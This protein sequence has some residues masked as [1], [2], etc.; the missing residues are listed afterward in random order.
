MTSRLYCNIR[1][2]RQRAVLHSSTCQK[3]HGPKPSSQASQKADSKTLCHLLQLD[4]A[5]LLHGC[6]TIATIL[7]ATAIAAATIGA[8]IM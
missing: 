2:T 1:R 7:L 3:V 4:L 6:R 5:A 8:G